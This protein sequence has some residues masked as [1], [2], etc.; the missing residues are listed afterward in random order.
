MTNDIAGIKEADVIL[1][2]G[3]D[4]SSAAHPIIAARIKQAVR[5]GKPNWIYF[6]LKEIEMA[7]YATI[8]ARHRCGDRCRCLERD[9]ARDYS[10]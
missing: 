1:I 10:T 5:F 6:D 4:N 2:I 8:Y 3:S 9:Y 7:K